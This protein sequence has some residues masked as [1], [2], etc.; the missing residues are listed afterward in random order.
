[1]AFFGIFIRHLKQEVAA[2]PP[3]LIFVLILIRNDI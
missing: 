2:Y 3:T 1:M